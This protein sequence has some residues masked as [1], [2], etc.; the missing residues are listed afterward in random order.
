MAAWH[1][2]DHITRIF[3]VLDTVLNQILQVEK[4]VIFMLIIKCLKNAL[5]SKCLSEQVLGLKLLL[6][7]GIHGRSHLFQV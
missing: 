1:D 3:L 2:S 7:I 4:P 5:L 6:M